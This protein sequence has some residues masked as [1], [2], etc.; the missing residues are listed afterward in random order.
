MKKVV[1]VV[2]LLLLASVASAEDC[3]VKVGQT[4]GFKS[5][6]VWNAFKSDPQMIVINT[7]RGIGSGDIIL[8]QKE[9]PIKIRSTDSSLDTL[10]LVEV[11]GGKWLVIKN[12][13]IC[14]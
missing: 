11:N 4:W 14:N 10:A 8:I 2:T 9:T 6:V 13:L 12:A 1:L 5:M 7:L 3:R